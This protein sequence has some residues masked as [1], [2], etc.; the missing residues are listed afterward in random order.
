MS[1]S[2]KVKVKTNSGFE[3][4]IDTRIVKDWKFVKAIQKTTSDD[5]QVQ[6]AGS[7]EVVHLFLGDTNENALIKHIESL[8]DGYCPM[9][10]MDQEVKEML[11]SIKNEDSEVK[12]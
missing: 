5:P 2:N 11:E 12:K 3:C 8:N 6:M 1:N 7:Y 9:D 10:V 4:E